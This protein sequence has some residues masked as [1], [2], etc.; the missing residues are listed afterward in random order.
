MEDC[1]IISSN[2][3]WYEI[4]YNL[5]FLVA[6]VILLFE[7]YKRKIPILKWIF[8]LIITRCAFILGTKIITFSPDDWNF[9]FTHLKFPETS[10]KSLLGGLL[11]GSIS[12]VG[13]FY[14]FRFKKNITDAFAFALPVGFAIQRIGCFLTGCCF[15]KVSYL[16]WAVKY[17]VQTLPHYHHFNDNIITFGNFYSLPVHPVQLYEIILMIAAVI[18]LYIYR[19]RLKIPGSLFL[20]SCILIFAARFT[21]E[22]FRDVHAHTIGGEQFLIFNS[23]QLFLLPIIA[24]LIFLIVRREKQGTRHKSST[25]SEDLGLTQAFVLLLVLSLGFYVLKNGFNFSEQ[26]AIVTVFLLS[27]V[28][29]AYRIVIQVYNSPYRWLY[30][31]GIVFPLILMAQ[32]FPADSLT[33]TRYKTLKFGVAS[34]EFENLYDLGR[35]E[36][37]DRVSNTE[38][39]NQ[40]YTLGAMALEST[41]LNPENGTAF[42][43]GGKF[44]FGNHEETRISDN[45]VVNTTIY[46][47]TPYILFDSK[48]GGIGGGLHMGNL[49]YAYEDKQADGSGIPT[50]GSN[51]VNVYPQFYFRF[52]VERYFFVDY[53]LAHHFPSALPAYRH[54]LGI[55]SGLGTKNGTKLRIGSDLGRTIYL[56]GYVPINNKFVLEPAV[57]WENDVRYSSGPL[58]QF[59]MGVG[60][61]FGYKEVKVRNDLLH[62]SVYK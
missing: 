20:L 55:G 25:Q 10:Q 31:G 4:L 9:L 36:G 54:Q 43:Y 15:G 26:L 28:I 8:F 23:T 46:G 41:T 34:G 29:I 47:L 53:H 48:W 40:K 45:I 56:S 24:L 6:L 1:L 42:T 30:L 22:F 38:Y 61:R 44:M 32:T 50:S 3:P 35:G 13:G 7:G 60:Y 57:L 5:A 2:G 27:A 58:F 37:C 62:P 49:T 14:L 11:L 52:G 17:P 12:L 19:K 51:T 59:S 18:F 33:L 21:S 16:P 39:F